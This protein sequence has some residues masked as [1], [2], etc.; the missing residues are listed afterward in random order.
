MKSLKDNVV[1][2]T[3]PLSGDFGR[4]GL[5]SSPIDVIT[6]AI[7]SGFRRFDSA[8]NYGYGAGEEILG[9]ALQRVDNTCVEF[10]TKLGNH[11]SGVKNFN[12]ECMRQTFENTFQKFGC[13]P[14]S[15]LIH[16][17]RHSPNELE[18]LVGEITTWLPPKV[19][20]GISLA[21]DTKYPNSILNMFEYIQID[22]NYLY[23]HP[24]ESEKL[25]TQARSI[26]GSGLLMRQCTPGSLVFDTDDHRASWVVGERKQ[27]IN[28]KLQSFDHACATWKV[29]RFEACLLLGLVY[30]GFNSCVVGIKNHLHLKQLDS[31][32]SKDIDWV[33]KKQVSDLR[34]ELCI[35]SGF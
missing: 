3:W 32:L 33:T 10:S 18:D 15:A 23:R 24:I 34:K 16:N 12:Q 7:E 1:I 8:P 35:D 22:A 28:K 30:G 5:A 17:P 20:L 14:S 31:F 25:S 19:K 9:K 26:L 21:K 2:G 13:M 27:L 4:K 11:V 29:S 6:S